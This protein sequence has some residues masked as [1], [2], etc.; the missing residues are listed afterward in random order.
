M[1]SKNEHSLMLDMGNLM[2]QNDKFIPISL[3]PIK[4][5]RNF[6]EL[7][8]CTHIYKSIILILYVI[9]FDKLLQ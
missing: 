4:K 3:A 1:S 8:I 6:I 5:F 7:E 9:I 2:V